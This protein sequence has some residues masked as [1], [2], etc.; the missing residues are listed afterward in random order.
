MPRETVGEPL[1]TLEMGGQ[2]P[3]LPGIRA[4]YAIRTKLDAP[5]YTTK[6]QVGGSL[7]LTENAAQTARE[8]EANG[9]YLSTAKKRYLDNTEVVS[10]DVN[11][12]YSTVWEG[13]KIH[14]QTDGA[15]H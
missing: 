3:N 13:V 8:N 2:V 5:D 10:L 14:G 11:E 15:T 4:H 9:Q 12:E 6:G 1:S 7:F